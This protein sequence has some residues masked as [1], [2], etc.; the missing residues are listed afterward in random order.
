L[1]RELV[2][3]ATPGS[4]RICGAANWAVKYSG[5]IRDGAFGTYTDASVYQ[6]NNCG[7]GVLPGAAGFDP[8]F[9]T[10]TDYRERVGEEP[11]PQSYFRVHDREQ[12]VRYPLFEHVPVRDRTVADIGCAGGSFLDGLGGFAA[13][14][15]GVE[16]AVSY[17]AS[18]RQRGHHVFSSVAEAAK[19]WGSKVDVAVCFSVIEHVPDPIEF[20]RDIRALLAPAGRLLV[21]TPNTRDIL[22]E[23][24][25]QAYRQFFYRSVHTYYF[26][27]ASLKAAGAAAGFP[28]FEP[29]YIH[30]FNF[31]N[32]V[33]WLSQHKPTSNTG[34]SLLGRGF[35]RTWK[36]ELEQNGHA[37][38]LYAWFSVHE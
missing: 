6:C 28:Y 16:P 25:C 3:S 4:C 9:Y 27:A 7:V 5:P 35:D 34:P 13:A 12:F 24:G 32:F 2:T 10:G 36:A 20:L 11:D 30:R 38:Y 33:N 26:D 29:I 17:H 19:E 37:D 14:T 22:L 21:S 15:I 8:A 1:A 31:A 23:V 18:L